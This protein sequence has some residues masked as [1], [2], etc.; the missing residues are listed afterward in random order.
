MASKVCETKGVKYFNFCNKTQNTE[1]EAAE[2]NKLEKLHFCSL[3]N[4]A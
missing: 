1:W 3:G 4:F 2:N